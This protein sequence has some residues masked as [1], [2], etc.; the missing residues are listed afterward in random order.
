MGRD[1][2]RKLL[3]GL[4]WTVVL[5]ALILIALLGYG[6]SSRDARR[7][8]TFCNGVTA[9]QTNPEFR[10]VGLEYCELSS[11]AMR[12]RPF[13]VS[14]TRLVMALRSIPNLPD[15][16][17]ANSSSLTH[18]QFFSH[19][20][21]SAYLFLSAEQDVDDM[22]GMLQELAQRKASIS[23][24]DARAFLESF[25]INPPP[26]T[27]AGALASVR[28]LMVDINPAKP[29]AIRKPV[30]FLLTTH[31][32]AVMARKGYPMALKD[33]SVQQEEVVWSE[34]DAEVKAN[35]YELWR[36]KQVNDFLDGIWARYGETY[37]SKLIGPML[38][39]RAVCRPAA[40]ILIV[41]ALWW[42]WRKRKAGDEVAPAPVA[43]T[44]PILNTGVPNQ[45]A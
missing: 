13:G 3:R 25:K 1:W 2:R 28:K 24:E 35:D 37:Q 31:I 11:L 38:K 12:T 23:D 7:M 21:L 8:Q 20:P 42:F 39:I 5:G 19:G 30:T 34:L 22:T 4:R 26:V 27:D 17:K 33:L 15:D 16:L 45:A 18:Y 40:P 32:H 9:W 10:H 44:T 36:T 29:F 6:I 14:A 41:L 43:A